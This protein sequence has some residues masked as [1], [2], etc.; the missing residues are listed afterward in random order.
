MKLGIAA[1]I[2]AIFGLGALLLSVSM[3]GLSY[4]TTRHFLVA[5]RETA[6]QHQ[7]FINANLVRSALIAGET[8]YAQLLASLDAGSGSHSVLYHLGKSYSGSLS[9]SASAIPLA[10]RTEVLSGTVATQTYRTGANVTEI[11][12]GIPV[13][14]VHAA[15]FEVFSLSDLDHTLRVLG[16]T[17]IVVGAI[18]TVLGAALGRFASSRS[19]RPLAGVSRAAVAIAGRPPGHPARS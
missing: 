12:V 17:L 5:E 1:R 9:L 16:S 6:A 2:T 4:F 11:A 3:G 18:T 19:L 13:P 15:Y 10:L 7:A 14:S 8:K